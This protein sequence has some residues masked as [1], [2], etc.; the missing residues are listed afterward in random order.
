MS[1][2]EFLIFHL[3]LNDFFRFSRAF[4]WVIKS[5]EKSR[6]RVIETH[7]PGWEIIIASPKTGIYVEV[8]IKVERNAPLPEFSLVSQHDAGVKTITSKLWAN[9]TRRCNSSA[10]DGGQEED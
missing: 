10:T 9:H 6:D 3:E 5:S 4:R 7:E 2:H 1:L 8:R